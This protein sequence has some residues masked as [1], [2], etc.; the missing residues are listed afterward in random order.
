MRWTEAELAW[1]REYAPS[2]RSSE[3]A[4]AMRELFGCERSVQSISQQ[5]YRMGLPSPGNL[6]QTPHNLRNAGEE[7][8]NPDGRIK[9]KDC[10]G[11]WV[12][13]AR[14]VWERVNGRKLPEKCV[15]VFADRNRSNYDPDN[16]V[17]VERAHLATI[18]KFGLQFYDADSLQACVAFAK[19]RS[20]LKEKK[21][22][23]QTAARRRG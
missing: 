15:V 20:K 11:R 6:G 1:F 23:I 17:C 16:L 14:V 2:H 18:N 9:V 22:E 4:E 7:Q 21:D 19:V 10:D 8:A 13:K 12:D 5:R 3:I